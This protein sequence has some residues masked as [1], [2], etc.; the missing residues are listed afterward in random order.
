MSEREAVASAHPNAQ[1]TPEACLS[2]MLVAGAPNALD[3]VDGRDGIGFGQQDREPVRAGPSDVIAAARRG[4]EDRRGLDRCLGGCNRSRRC[5]MAREAGQLHHDDGRRPAIAHAALRFGHEDRGPEPA[6]KEAGFVVVPVVSPPIV[7][8]SRLERRPAAVD[9]ELR[10]CECHATNH[11][12]ECGFGN[13]RQR[14]LRE[15]ARIG[16]MGLR[17]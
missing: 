15:R 11:L 4:F 8:R 12:S 7:G 13:Q 16:A 1:R 14:T 3:V 9:L 6:T 17:S 5:R 2:S 10:I